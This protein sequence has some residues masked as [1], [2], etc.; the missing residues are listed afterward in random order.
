MLLVDKAYPDL[1]NEAK[2]ML[3]LNRFFEKLVDLQIILAVKQQQPREI[4]ATVIKLRLCMQ[5]LNTRP[6]YLVVGNIDR[7]SNVSANLVCQP[8]IVF[9]QGVIV[10]VVDKLA[11]QVEILE[12]LLHNKSKYIKVCSNGGC[13]GQYC[14]L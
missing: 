13:P 8:N 4:K 3:A 14:K 1:Q 10:D 6:S 5:L 11:T 7:P 12:G 2:D 9:N